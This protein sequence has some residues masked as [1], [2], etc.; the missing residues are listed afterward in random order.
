MKKQQIL[1]KTT[2]FRMKCLDD[3]A[4]AP[5]LEEDIERLEWMSP[6]EVFHVDGSVIQFGTLCYRQLL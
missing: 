1:K 5:Q 6:K 4:M 3:S 2:W